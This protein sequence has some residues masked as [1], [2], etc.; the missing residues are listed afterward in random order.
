[1]CSLRI[2]YHLGRVANGA[3]VSFSLMDNCVGQNKSN[4]TMQFAAMLS[5]LFY[6]KVVLLYLIP[7]HSHML[8]DRVVAWMKNK[9]RGKQIFHPDGLVEACN[10]INSVCADGSTTRTTTFS[11]QGGE[12]C[13]PSILPK[14]RQGSQGVTFMNLR[15]GSVRTDTSPLPLMLMQLYIHS[16]LPPTRQI[17]ALPLPLSSSVVVIRQSGRWRH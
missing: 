2:N 4:V 9:I 6:K 3:E 17:Y 11:G 7:G 14:C 1:M 10:T 5:F 8:P 16:A 13:C 12:G 15:M